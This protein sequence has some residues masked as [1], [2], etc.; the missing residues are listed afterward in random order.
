MF[1]KI[2]AF[3]NFANS[4]RIIILSNNQALSNIE[5]QLLKNVSNTE[6]KLKKCTAYINKHIYSCK[7]GIERWA[8][9]TG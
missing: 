2:G 4:T 3:E 7:H 1:F 5:S 9:F 8:Y 6:A